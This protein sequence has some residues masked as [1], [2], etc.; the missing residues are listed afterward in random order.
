MLENCRKQINHVLFSSKQ[1]NW[2]IEAEVHFQI[3]QKLK[4]NI[5]TMEF[6]GAAPIF[7]P[8]SDPHI[9]IKHTLLQ[10]VQVKSLKWVNKN[11]VKLQ[12]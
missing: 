4:K 1:L 7:G 5:E 6:K 10:T 8:S 9:F 11:K 2:T 12:S 3:S